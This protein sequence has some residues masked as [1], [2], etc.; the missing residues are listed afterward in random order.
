MGS[1][2]KF[3]RNNA[4]GAYIKTIK[5]LNQKELE[6]RAAAVKALMEPP[7]EEAPKTSEDKND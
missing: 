2:R 1:L 6:Q 3:H 5:K 4:K 7:K